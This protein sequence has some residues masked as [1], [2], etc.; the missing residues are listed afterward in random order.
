MTNGEDTFAI[1]LSLASRNIME[2]RI[3]LGRKA[4]SN[5]YLINPGVKQVQKVYSKK[6]LNALYANTDKSRIV[7]NRI[8]SKSKCHLA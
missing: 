3:L 1:E 2:F 5:R 7:K 8:I 4:I 6:E